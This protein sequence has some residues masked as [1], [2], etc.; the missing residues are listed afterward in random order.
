[1]SV[2]ITKKKTVEPFITA[3]RHPPNHHSLQIS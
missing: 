1:L 2:F 3:T